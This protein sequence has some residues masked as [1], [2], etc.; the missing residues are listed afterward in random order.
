MSFK[1]CLREPLRSARGSDRLAD[2]VD[3]PHDSFWPPYGHPAG[4]DNLAEP[5]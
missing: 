2:I 4:A 5:K 1:H 3:V